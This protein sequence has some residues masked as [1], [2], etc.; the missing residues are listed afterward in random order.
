[1]KRVYRVMRDQTT[2]A[3]APAQTAGVARRHEGRVAVD[4]SNTRWCSDG[5]MQT[6]D[7][8][9]RA[10]HWPLSSIAETGG[11]IESLLVVINTVVCLSLTVRGKRCPVFQGA[12]SLPNSQV[13]KS[14]VVSYLFLVGSCLR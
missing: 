9:N 1:M 2:V 11:T 8:F 4:T 14:L 7:R 5:F 13:N 12:H 10:Q 6:P 3:G